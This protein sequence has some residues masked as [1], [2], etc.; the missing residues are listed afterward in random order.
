MR[1]R[2]IELSNFMSHRST[3]VELPERGLVIV[4]G[5][6]GSGKSSL[7][8]GVSVA[9]WNKTLRGSTPWQEGAKDCSASVHADGLTFERGRH[10]TKTNVYWKVVDDGTATG[11]QYDALARLGALPGGLT[12]GDAFESTTQAQE[13]LERL[14]GPWD[15]WRRAYAFSSSDAA[16]FSLSTDGE[17]K[18]LLESIL[19]LARFDVALERCRADLKQAES[20]VLNLEHQQIVLIQKLKGEETRLDDA[21]KILARS[22]EDIPPALEAPTAADLAR[23]QELVKGCQEDI[24]KC[25]AQLR[26]TDRAQ[27][28]ADSNA[29]AAQAA[30]DRLKNVRCP[31]CDQEIGHDLRKHLDSDVKMTRDAAEKAR[32]E[33]SAARGDVEANLAELQAERDVLIRKFSELGSSQ[34]VAKERHELRERML[35]QAKVATQIRDS[36]SKTVDK[37]REEVAGAGAAVTEGIT[38]NKTLRAVES[39]L[40]LRGVRAHVLAKSLSGLTAVANAWLPRLGLPDLSVTLKPYSEKKSGG[41]TDSISIEVSGAGGGNGYRGA[42]AGERRRI[43][44]ALLLAISEVA[45]A[46]FGR[47]G[48]TMF[49]DELFDALDSDGVK[50]V[51]LALDELSQDRC[52]VVITHNDELAASLH[53]VKRIQIQEGS[54]T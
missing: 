27:V 48:S 54:T 12:D 32:R 22:Q 21:Q 53:A 35:N 11:R 30:A 10:K 6:N 9:G 47:S 16:H 45:G 29:R 36:V 4:Q 38:R 8:E 41:V 25:E 40:G 33:A 44:L 43:D 24:R 50:A 39:V 52:V 37:L 14:I 5:P 42:S 17:R 34:R 51:S 23:A 20:N 31:T 15:V 46:S 13:A 26:E 18:R 19:G 2:S 28:Q 7:I 49:F 3:K 1:V